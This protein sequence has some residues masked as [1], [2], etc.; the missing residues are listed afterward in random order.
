MGERV[1]W[2]PWKDPKRLNTQN[3]GGRGEKEKVPVHNGT[4]GKRRERGSHFRF[5]RVKSISGGGREEMEPIN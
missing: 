4:T 5:R 3:W 1:L 2:C